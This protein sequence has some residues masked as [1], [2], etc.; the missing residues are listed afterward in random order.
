MEANLQ[1]V[2]TPLKAMPV[3]VIQ[4]DADTAVPVEKPENGSPR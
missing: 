1:A 3:I 2:L 4:G